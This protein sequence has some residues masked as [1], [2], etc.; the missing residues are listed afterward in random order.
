MSL[1]A[2]VALNAPYV[3]EELNT[4]LMLHE[5]GVVRG[6]DVTAPDASTLRISSDATAGGKAVVHDQGVGLV[7]SHYGED[8]VDL[9]GVTTERYLA[10]RADYDR[11]DSAVPPAGSTT[12]QF[13]L[14]E[15]LQAGDLVL[16]ELN[17]SSVGG[18]L[19]WWPE[20]RQR[21]PGTVLVARK[22]AD[23]TFS[24]TSQFTEDAH[25]T[26]P[27]E[28]GAH[29]RMRALLTID[30]PAAASVNVEVRYNPNAVNQTVLDFWSFV[31]ANF[32]TDAGFTYTRDASPATL[33]ITSK[34]RSVLRGDVIFE[35]PSSPGAGE[36]H[37]GAAP[38]ALAVK[39]NAEI[40]VLEGSYLELT[41]LP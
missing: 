32:G 33:F 26:L 9:S 30:D 28:G 16:A 27:V 10:L 11:L 21:P 7:V 1:R 5:P 13:V 17:P 37:L 40:T 20:A 39:P 4:A 2:T 38:L 25:L 6:F 19:Q 35:A 29:Y 34:S 18:T 3:S 12:V 24:N 22:T 31:N 8:D 23:Q 14:R 36:S 41:R 15:T